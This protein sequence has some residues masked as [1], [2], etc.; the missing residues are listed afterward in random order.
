[1]ALST[2]GPSR[3]ATA[4]DHTA[5][6]AERLLDPVHDASAEDGHVHPCRADLVSRQREDVPRED[7]QV[8]KLAD[9]HGTLAILLVRRPCRRDRVRGDRLLDGERLLGMPGPPD[10]EGDVLERRE[11]IRPAV[12]ES[13][14]PV[15]DE[16]D[17]RAGRHHR[18]PPARWPRAA[19]PP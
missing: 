2:A 19:P 18:A 10:R 13:P 7:D 14:A 12:A 16:I 5:S 15:R 9:A 3:T 4:R 6:L 1:M 17:A 11:R 8:G